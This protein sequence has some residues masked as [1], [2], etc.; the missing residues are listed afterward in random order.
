MG[1][2]IGYIARQIEIEKNQREK[3]L[4]EAIRLED[5]LIL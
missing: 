4:D 3:L 2:R 5:E 1:K